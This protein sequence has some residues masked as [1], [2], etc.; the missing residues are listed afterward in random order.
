MPRTMLSRGPDVVAPPFGRSFLFGPVGGGASGVGVG[1]AASAG[2]G[3]VVL[4]FIDCPTR[5]VGAHEQNH[6]DH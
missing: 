6:E 2:L 1:L 5:T 3:F 4:P